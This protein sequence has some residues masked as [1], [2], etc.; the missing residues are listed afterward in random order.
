MVFQITELAWNDDNVEHIAR[1]G[2]EPE[3]VH[4]VVFDR[5]FHVTRLAGDRYLMIGRTSA[6][7]LLSVYVDRVND[8]TFYVVTARDATPSE[9]RLYQRHT[10]R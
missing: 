3:D 6:G 4:E 5:P 8:T 9:R 1:H 7:R 2:V 10:N